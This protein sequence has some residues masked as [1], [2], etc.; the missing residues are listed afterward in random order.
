MFISDGRR[1][2]PETD[3]ETRQHGA[4]HL[5]HILNHVAMARAALGQGQLGSLPDGIAHI[6]HHWYHAGIPSL[7]IEIPHR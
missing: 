1:I 2:E 3:P 5:Y 6:E 7:R 4:A